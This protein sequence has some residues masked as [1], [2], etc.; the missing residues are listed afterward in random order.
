LFQFTA[1]Q[2]RTILRAGATVAFISA[3]I[4]T[5]ASDAGGQRYLAPL[6]GLVVGILAFALV[7][8]VREW[9]WNSRLAELR[10]SVFSIINLG[11][12]ALAIL[13]AVQLSAALFGIQPRARTLIA[14]GLIAVGFTAWF[15]VDSFFGKGVLVGL[16]TGKYHHPR[17][18]N[19]IFLFADLAD[20]TPLAQSLGDLRYHT[21][22]NELFK[23]VGPSIERYSGSVHRYLG[24]EVIVTWT[25]D[26]GIRDAACLR[27]SAAILDAVRNAETHF[28]DEY[29]VAPRLRIGLHGGEV[30]TGEMSG[31]KREIVFSGDA[32][33]T[34]A[35]IQ[36]VASERDRSLVISEELLE[37]L[38]PGSDVSLE[39]L[40]SFQLKGRVDRTE[41]FA[42]TGPVA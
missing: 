39:P 11:L 18:E 2:W 25:W 30:V 6:F 33:N 24:D 29:G 7:V 16:L 4:S 41:L 32:V 8:V 40:G 28:R 9:V 3:A 37:A 35:R 20:S 27:C 12:N 13:T 19:R 10:F 1:R 22:L 21:L 14:A 36:S 38:G 34:T 17:Y 31:V 15:T 5:L 23:T 26:A 42:V